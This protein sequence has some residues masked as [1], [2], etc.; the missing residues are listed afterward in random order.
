MRLKQEIQA[1]LPERTK[2]TQGTDGSTGGRNKLI[3]K[4]FAF[5]PCQDNAR[6]RSVPVDMKRDTMNLRE[7]NQDTQRRTAAGPVQK[8]NGTGRKGWH[9]HKPTGP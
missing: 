9:V 7:D 4:N 5:I 8:V 2:R 1:L 3:T 6:A